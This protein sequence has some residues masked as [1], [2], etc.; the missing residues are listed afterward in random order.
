MA[1]HFVL[2]L[3]EEAVTDVRQ[4]IGYLHTGIEKTMEFRSWTQGVTF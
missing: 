2:T 1:R 3:S 4:S